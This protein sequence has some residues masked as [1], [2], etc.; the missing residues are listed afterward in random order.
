MEFY[1]PPEKSKQFEMITLQYFVLYVDFNY[2]HRKIDGV[3]NAWR[4]NIQ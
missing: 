1:D 4:E 3:E 2:A